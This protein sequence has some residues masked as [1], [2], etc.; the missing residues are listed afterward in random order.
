MQC[1]YQLFADAKVFDI[2][3]Y[4]QLGKEIPHQVVVIDEYADLMVDK[5][6][7]QEAEVCIQRLCREGAGCWFSCDSLHPAPGCQGGNPLNQ[8]QF[9]AKDRPQG[10]HE[11]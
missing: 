9:T 3:E 7:K 4:C 11:Y 1:C 10:N 8:G 2:E 6:Y 5:E